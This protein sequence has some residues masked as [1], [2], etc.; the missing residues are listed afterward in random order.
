ML[1]F[2]VVLPEPGAEATAPRTDGAAVGLS[3]PIWKAWPVQVVV[4]VLV[5]PLSI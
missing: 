5:I 1:E 4:V 3:V 2:T